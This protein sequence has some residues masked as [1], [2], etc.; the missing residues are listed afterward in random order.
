MSTLVNTSST[1]I[2]VVKQKYD[3]LLT[4]SLLTRSQFEG[5]LKEKTKV[6]S[7]LKVKEGKDID[8]MIEMDKQIKFLNEI[9]YKRNQSIQ[10]IH[11]LAPKCAT[12]HG[13][14]TFANP[15]YLKKAQSDKPRLYEIPY[16]TSDPANRFLP[17]GEDTVD[18]LKKCV[19]INIEREQYHEIQD[20]KAQ[21]QD[22]NMVINELKKL[23][24]VTKG[25]SVETQFDKPSV[26]RQPNAQRIP[27]PS[28]LGKPTP[29]SNSPEMRRVIH[30][31]S[32]SRPQLKSYQVKEKVVPNI[33]QIV[34][35]I[36]IIVDSGC[37]KHLTGNLQ[38]VTESRLR[39]F[40]SLSFETQQFKPPVVNVNDVLFTS[41]Q[42]S[43]S[44]NDFLIYTVQNSSI[45]TTAY[46]R[47][48]HCSFPTKVVPLAVK[49][50]TSRQELELLFHLHIAMLRTTGAENLA[51]DHLSR[52]E[53]P[54]LGTFTE[55]EIA[56]KFPDEHLMILKTKLNEDEPWYADYVNY[57]VG[58]IVPPNWTPE[59]R[60]RFFSQV[61]NYFWDEPYVFKLC[62][63]N[64]MRRCI[65]GN[66]ILEILA[67]CHSGPTRG[68]HSASITGRKVYES[69]FFWPSIFKYVK[70]YVMICDT[71][72]RSGN[73]P[74]RSEM[75]RN[76]I[77][78]EAQALPTNDARVVI[79]FLRRLFA[80]FGVPKGVTGLSKPV[81][82][83]KLL[84]QR[85][86]LLG[87]DRVVM[88]TQEYMKKV[89]E[90][91]GE[92]E[93]FKSGLWNGKL[94]QVVAIVKSCSPNV[95]GDLTV[96]MKDLSG[97]IPGTI[98]HKVIGE[99]RYG[100]D[101]TIGVVLILA[102]VSVF[103]PKPSMHYLNITM[104][105]VVFR[106]D[107]GHGSAAA[108]NRFMELNELMELRDEAY[109]NTRIYNER[110]KRWH[111]S[112]LRGDK[113]FKVGD[114]VLLFKSRFKM[115]PGKLKSRLYRP[116][117]VKT[118]YPYETVE[119]IDRN[120]ISFKV[121]GQRLKKYH[122][123]HIDVEDK[124][125]VEFEEDTT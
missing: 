117:V 37:S 15:K 89:V 52:L 93:D 30:T 67:H 26:V 6:I 50:A 108:K 31:T 28:V 11:M 84:K 115:H 77:Q 21:M 48:V 47:Q 106:K 114:K 63:D 87:L 17:I 24:L 51:A 36:L 33:S 95:I 74:S 125:V 66:E 41:V 104:R 35:L 39:V 69:G 4:K 57:I 19:E 27:K 1:E 112:R 38:D 73:I 111:D 88:S 40:M 123:G 124:E 120:R 90:D 96:T 71:C 122:D 92:D 46:D 23:I 79:K 72:Q 42:A 101:I 54:D 22:K 110:T 65:V 98:H 94:D 29:F 9:L 7:D 8:T 25:K 14:S 56:D 10:T 12:Y 5:Q 83:T 121:N 18:S 107:T 64:V 43:S 105:N 55:E 113:N 45:K 103:S 62:P 91:V 20:L 70:D 44:S 76:N 109:E 102:N 82:F 59:K 100:K 2:S 16:D 32:V 116:N 118:V 13:R 85:D 34:Q 78:V 97:T 53:N 68:H 80:R 81:K 75:P 58:K 119:I 49:T 3:E 99:G 61:K 60:R 86:I